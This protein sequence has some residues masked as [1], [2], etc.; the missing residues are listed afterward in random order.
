MADT[1]SRDVALNVIGKIESY[2]KELEKVPGVTQKSAAKAALAMQNTFTKDLVKQFKEAEKAA[3]R[4]AG[5]WREIFGMV[6]SHIGADLLKSLAGSIASMKGDLAALTGEINTYSTATGLSAESVNA[7]RFAMESQGRTFDELGSALENF[8]ERMEQFRQGGGEAAG[9]MELLGFKSK[10]ANKLIADMG[11]TFEEVIRRVQGLPN[12]AH[13]AAIMTSLFGDS[14]LY[15]STALGD[16]PLEEWKDRA[17]I[18]IDVSADAVAANA[19]WA[20]TVA[21]LGEAFQRTKQDALGL[22]DLNG[23][24]KT[25]GTVFVTMSAAVVGGLDEVLQ[26]MSWWITTLRMLA[27]GDL[28]SANE[29]SA[30]VFGGLKESIQ[31]VIDEAALAGRE[32]Y[33]V[34]SS[35]GNTAAESTGLSTKL[36]KTTSEMKAAAQAAAELAKKQKELRDARIE[37]DEAFADVSA[38]TA[39]DKLYQEYIKRNREFLFET[40]KENKLSRFEI[41]RYK[42]LSE[43]KY[44]QDSKALRDKDLE[45][46][47]DAAQE[48]ADY[49]KQLTD[50]KTEQIKQYYQDIIDLGGEFAGIVSD[51]LGG[52]FD[53]MAQARAKD[54]ASAKKSVGRQKDLLSDLYSEIES[55]DTKSEAAKLQR[56]V[57]ARK[58]DLAGAREQVRNAKDAMREVAVMQKA[59]GLFSIGLS[60]AQAVM[61]AWA[62]VPP[63]FTLAAAIAAGAAGAAQMAIAAATPLPTF[64]GGTSRIASGSNGEVQVTAHEG[65]A[66]LNAR[67]VDRLGAGLIDALNAGL[68]P[69][70]AFSGAG[71]GGGDVYLDGAKVGEVMSRGQRMAARRPTGF[72]SPYGRR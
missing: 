57:D 21:I 15:L 4:S 10:D 2:Q 44:Y 28:K 69:I 52:V 43:E 8:P 30:K 33:S 5:N 66:M 39:Q 1:L 62:S 18:G 11:G 6:S 37:V 16:V 56:R 46:S 9:M 36:G 61:L 65:E 45:D 19:A 50:E 68:S 24:A 3:A 54:L 64:F 53:L 22:I 71:G 14:A 32:F 13:R 63:P 48:M 70:A 26:R 58:E 29:A 34:A 42:K 25:L 38:L 23:L 55:A 59:Q 40:A 51:T 72:R 41:D 47:K 31:G 67:A 12:E 60:T 49:A 20:S 27:K 7:L 17:K 35:I